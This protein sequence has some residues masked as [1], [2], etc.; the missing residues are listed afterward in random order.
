MVEAFLQAEPRMRPWDG[1]LFLG[2]I[3]CIAYLLHRYTAAYYERRRVVGRARG[4]MVLVHKSPVE[5]A[6]HISAMCQEGQEPVAEPCVQSQ[7]VR[8]DTLPAVL[9]EEFPPELR[10]RLAKLRDE[11]YLQD[12]RWAERVVEDTRG[13]GEKP[14]GGRDRPDEGRIA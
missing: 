9:L 4:S 7:A 11:Y 3:A 13:M 2:L 5:L 6:G 1:F 8:W 12:R 10:E 14:D